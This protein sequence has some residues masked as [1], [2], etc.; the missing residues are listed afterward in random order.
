M[1]FFRIVRVIPPTFH[2]VDYVDFDDQTFKTGG[3]KLESGE[4][5]LHIALFFE[6]LEL[7]RARLTLQK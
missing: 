2:P 1:A 5:Y 7:Y 6:N 3:E 4:D